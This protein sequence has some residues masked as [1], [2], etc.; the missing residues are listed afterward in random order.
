MEFHV[1][2]PKGELKP[3]IVFLVHSSSTNSVSSIFHV[4][5]LINPAARSVGGDSVLG[6]AV[7]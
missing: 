6:K 4:D 3:L 7:P 2:A 1:L 5:R